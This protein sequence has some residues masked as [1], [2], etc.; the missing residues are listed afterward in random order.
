MSDDG[1]DPPPPETG[2]KDSPPTVPDKGT[3]LVDTG[4]GDLVRDIGR[5]GSNGSKHNDGDPEAP[6]RLP[7]T[8]PDSA[9][10]P[11]A[12]TGNGVPLFEQP[13]RKSQ[14]D[15]MKELMAL[16]DEDGDGTIE[17]DEL[18]VA[19]K[20]FKKMQSAKGTF[21][22]SCFPA[23]IQET[24][25]FFD[26]DG[27]GNVS[28]DEVAHAARLY[29]ESKDAQKKL[30]RAVGIISAVLA[31]ALLAIFGLTFAVVEL[32]K[33]TKTESSGVTKVKGT[34]TPMATAATSLDV[35]LGMMPRLG[36]R[37]L[38]NV[39]DIV[40][41]NQREQEVKRVV[42]G[43]DVTS[44][45]TMTLRT[46]LG[47]LLIVENAVAATVTFSGETPFAVCAAC[48]KCASFSVAEN[49][50]TLAVRDRYSRDAAE[51]L[52]T[53]AAPACVGKVEGATEHR[54]LRT[55]GDSRSRHA[56]ALAVGDV[57]GTDTGGELQCVEGTT[58][59]SALAEITVLGVVQFGVPT[60]KDSAVV[61]PTPDPPPAPTEVQR[62]PDEA[63]RHT[64]TWMAWASSEDI[65]G[66]ELLPTAQ[67]D[68][69]RIATTIAKY[70]PVHMVVPSTQ[71]ATAQALIAGASGVTLVQGNSDD[72]WMRDTGPVFV[73]RGPLDQ[74]KTL[75]AV[76]F[77][78]N[79]W[80]GKQNYS[81][82]AVVADLVA[83][84]AAVPLVTSTL[85]TEGGCIEVDGMGTAI[86][87]ES[88]V[89]NANRN[90][91]ATKR[92]VE[93]ELQKQLGIT[94]IIWLPGIAGKDI[95]D[96]HTDFY[97][98]FTAPGKV[99]AHL[100]TDPNS[101]DKAVTERHL[102]ILQAATDAQGRLLQVT[103]LEAPH[104]IPAAF[105]KW[106]ANFT[107]G[108]VNFYVGNGFVLLPKF[109]DTARDDAA[110]AAL[111]AAY[112][113]RTVEQ[114]E[115]NGIAAGGGGIHCTT[116][117]QPEPTQPTVA[118][119]PPV[120]L[121]P[122]VRVTTAPVASLVTPPPAPPV[123]M[124]PIA[125]S[126][127]TA[128]VVAT[129]ATGAPVVATT[130]TGAPAVMTTAT[131]A[132]A[133]MTTAP[134]VMTTDTGA[135]AAATFTNAPIASTTALTTAPVLSAGAFT[136][137]PLGGAGVTGAPVAA[138]VATLAPVASLVTAAPVVTAFTAAPLVPAFTVP[139]IAVATLAPTAAL[140]NI[141]V[142]LVTV[143]EG[144][145]A[146]GDGGTTCIAEKQ[147][148]IVAAQGMDVGT[149]KAKC[150]QTDWCNFIS[151]I[152]PD[153]GQSMMCWL[154][155]DCRTKSVN[156]Y[157]YKAAAYQLQYKGLH[158]AVEADL[159]R[160]TKD[161]VGVALGLAAAGAQTD[162][163]ATVEY[164]GD[165]PMIKY[166]VTLRGALASGSPE[167][168]AKN[169]AQAIK[170][171]PHGRYYPI[172]HR[173][174]SWNGVV[175]TENVV[176]AAQTDAKYSPP[177]TAP[178]VG[179]ANVTNTT[180]EQETLQAIRRRALPR[181]RHSG[182]LEGHPFDMPH[183]S[184]RRGGPAGWEAGLEGDQ[185]RQVMPGHA[186]QAVHV[187]LRDGVKH[188]PGHL[189]RH[190]GARCDGPGHLHVH[191]SVVDHVGLKPGD[192][193]YGTGCDEWA[194]LPFAARILH[195]HPHVDHP[196]ATVVHRVVPV[197]VQKVIGAFSF[198]TY[199]PPPDT[200]NASVRA[201]CDYYAQERF[202][203]WRRDAGG[204]NR[205]VT[206]VHDMIHNTGLVARLRKARGLGSD[207]PVNLQKLWTLSFPGV[208]LQNP[209][210][211]LY[212]KGTAAEGQQWMDGLGGGFG[213]PSGVFVSLDGVPP[214]LHLV[215]GSRTRFSL[216]LFIRGKGG[217]SFKCR[218]CWCWPPVK[219]RISKYG[220]IRYELRGDMRIKISPYFENVGPF[221]I[222]LGF[223][224]DKNFQLLAYLGVG[225][226]FETGIFFSATQATRL[227]VGGAE[228]HY[229]ITLGKEITCNE[230][231]HTRNIGSK[232]GWVKFFGPYGE[233]PNE[234]VSVSAGL[235]LQIAGSVCFPMCP[236]DSGSVTILRA[237]VGV[238][239][240]AYGNVDL[241]PGCD[242]P[243]RKWVDQ[244]GVPM[245]WCWWG[246]NM[247]AVTGA[248]ACKTKTSS[249]SNTGCLAQKLVDVCPPM[250]DYP[251]CERCPAGRCD[252]D[253]SGNC[254][255]YGDGYHC[256]V[257]NSNAKCPQ[258]QR[259]WGWGGNK[260]YSLVANWPCQ[261]S[262]ASKPEVS[263]KVDVEIFLELWVGIE[264]DTPIGGIDFGLT[265]KPLAWIFNLY[266]SP[267][268][269]PK[270]LS[271]LSK[272]YRFD[273]RAQELAR[274]GAIVAVTSSLDFPVVTGGSTGPDGTR[275]GPPLVVGAYLSNER[276]AGAPEDAI[277]TATLRTYNYSQPLA[278]SAMAVVTE[279]HGFDVNHPLIVEVTDGQ[280]N[281]SISTT[282]VFHI[283]PSHSYTFTFPSG[284]N[285]LT[286]QIPMATDGQLL[287]VRMNPQSSADASFY[288]IE[289]NTAV[290]GADCHAAD[291]EVEWRWDTQR[292]QW[293][294]DRPQVGAGC[295]FYCHSSSGG[296]ARTFGDSTR[297]YMYMIITGVAHETVDVSA[298]HEA[299]IPPGSEVSYVS[300]G[301]YGPLIS[302]AAPPTVFV[303]NN[304][305]AEPQTT[306]K[307]AFS[308]ALT[309]ADSDAGSKVGIPATQR[310]VDDCLQSPAM[311]CPIMTWSSWCSV[312]GFREPAVG[313]S[314]A[315][316]P[317]S[318]TAATPVTSD[319][320]PRV[321]TQVKSSGSFTL[322]CDMA[323]AA[324]WDK[325]GPLRVSQGE[326]LSVTVPRSA[327]GPA[328]EGGTKGVCLQL[329]ST[330]D[331]RL[332]WLVGPDL[333]FSPEKVLTAP[334]CYQTKTAAVSVGLA[335]ITPGLP[336]WV[337]SDALALG[338]PL[339]MLVMN[340]AG[341]D[342][343]DE[344]PPAPIMVTLESPLPRMA[345]GL[346][347]SLV[348]KTAANYMVAMPSMMSCDL[349]P[350]RFVVE[351]NCGLW[352]PEDVIP[353][354]KLLARVLK[355]QDDPLA[356][357]SIRQVKA[358]SMTALLLV[359][360]VPEPAVGIPGLSDGDSRV[361][362]I[363]LPS[364]TAN[365]F[366]AD[367]PAVDLTLS[368]DAAAIC[369]DGQALKFG[370]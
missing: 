125:T 208:R 121:A 204:H 100:D 283:H 34:D 139:P 42:A 195:V 299:R 157:A 35:P 277:G 58:N 126:V 314:P 370:V 141:T 240:K 64:R 220:V 345:G 109:G 96:G 329:N 61:P 211:V 302:C 280:G 15:A 248:H 69:A 75:A 32:S 40:L 350:A 83:A 140:V 356:A 20:R 192:T 9:G 4:N 290:S 306:P 331:D 31:F 176:A 166:A 315:V 28:K 16:F 110:Q 308:L 1:K 219:C 23:D 189:K 287:R 62:M 107:A 67:S 252:R 253:R 323:A 264:I 271:G 114:I 55:L 44:N 152:T 203:T 232:W 118:P 217:A 193:V 340:E 89:L 87:C 129:T 160:Y 318:P 161:R 185:V 339:R 261:G 327:L 281:M 36:S 111:Q 295:S 184:S 238:E 8:V 227:Y 93:Q 14:A 128:P 155:S 175:V 95:T 190:G 135:P 21:D 215:D 77:N 257:G 60:A 178:V 43:I 228:L 300:Q 145:H 284:S 317:A 210:Q 263:F 332:R 54:R 88:C 163:T 127:T 336:L 275:A 187:D 101:Y 362:R 236:G 51:L 17:I 156:T 47:D 347:Q 181:A 24:M 258:G 294:Y 52:R 146:V 235:F 159:I 260:Y 364:D 198:E 267:V 223:G 233:A 150:E 273:R 282:P 97:A 237:T 359:L 86:V 361:V 22:L 116:Q 188:I 291:T 85:V 239:L 276:P 222:R 289:E 352:P 3:G 279:T 191:R 328:S 322:R 131:G 169:I 6:G 243:E 12:D 167:D 286:V 119:I 321:W 244:L 199:V 265:W 182:T 90:P 39:G 132:P 133:V 246:C 144:W 2:E 186:W 165:A 104:N 316:L 98:R 207:W 278:T 272:Q 117:Q 334:Q 229:G 53:G 214:S 71:M 351:I 84:Q 298:V 269:R 312:S 72:L 247:D 38:R 270:F 216:G 366:G 147:R 130:V 335:E 353:E 344:P 325:A 249:R 200:A 173:I 179:T 65:W 92:Q 29:V 304:N 288:V 7:G 196:N 74:A 224:M 102:S 206:E 26:V 326:Q 292:A 37:Y 230:K 105:Q 76:K 307:V 262:K 149:C 180:T 45:E 113:S 245:T 254:I 297:A 148:D 333:R 151:T 49:D 313:T 78:F 342:E 242:N 66:T 209:V 343:E 82:D 59:P 231:C 365:T 285:A 303:R 341:P 63:G 225:L 274:P 154:E 360:V 5:P 358:I 19:A 266:V 368:K 174:A 13:K 202:D 134:A 50:H 256:K 346:R 367:L 201:D 27:D 251:G 218:S 301:G 106:Q 310:G 213:W 369:P 80:G 73:E 221:E 48:S 70:E 11:A 30:V 153:E 168:A 296:C 311:V 293:T 320:L 33:E 164:A 25:Q 183:R 171:E 142:P 94:K 172:T 255:T 123:T 268:W 124:A 57:N 337:S 363:H 68:L 99:V 103:T 162:V 120:T 349:A 319:E 250:D 115:I 18:R 309:Q 41:H 338:L 81:K 226:H 158:P 136:T 177:A 143:D 330:N 10:A 234:P 357:A 122:F 46:T 348:G 241:L 112:P 108:Y 138:G 259:C 137:A 324:D 197:P 194:H 91:G 56:R 79:G 354:D 212:S 355:Q 205:R 305:S 170:K